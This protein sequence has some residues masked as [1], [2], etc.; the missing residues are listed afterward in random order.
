MRRSAL[1]ALV[2]FP[3]LALPVRAPAEVDLEA[4]SAR[5]ISHRARLRRLKAR[6][7]RV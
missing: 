2:L 4:V 1:L 5:L 6:R 7:D 3:L